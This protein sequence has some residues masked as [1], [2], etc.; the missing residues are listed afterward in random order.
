M[1]ILMIE[2][3]EYLGESIKYILKKNNYSVDL[4]LDGEYGLDCALTNIYDVIILDIMLPKID[5]ITILKE[6]RKNKIRIPIIMLTARDSVEDKVIGLNNG[7]D[8]YLAKP[9]ETEEL[10]ARIK[11]ISRRKYEFNYDNT[12]LK[13]GNIILNIEK[14][15]LYCNEKQEKLSIKESQILELLMNNSEK[16]VSKENIILKVWGYD[17]EI[18]ENQVEIYISLIR[19][20]LKKIGAN[21]QIQTQ[22][23]R[24]YILLKR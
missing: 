12:T 4:A 3:E 15:I 8:D 18:N 16:V 5:G 9:F 21:V 13:F 20:K 1:K 19:K 23:M 2:D 7:A 10:L 22:R 6:I 24:G 17:N 14:L 11:A